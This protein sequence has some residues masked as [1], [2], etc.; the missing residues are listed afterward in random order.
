MSNAC[1]PAVVKSAIRDAIR[2]GRSVS[3]MPSRLDTLV[4]RVADPQLRDEL[5]TAVDDLRRI[6]DFGL[7]FEKHLPETVRLPHHSI[8]RG[9]KV[10]RR[11]LT[12]HSLFEVIAVNKSTATIRRLRHA[13][14][15]AVSRDEAR[16]TPKETAPIADLVALAE[17]GDPIYP[18]LRRIDGIQRGADKPSHVVINGE[19]YHTVQLLQFT[20]AA[21]VDFIYIDP[22]Y[23][24]TD[25]DWKYNNDYVDRDDA[26]RHSK[27]LAF[28]HRR[29]EQAKTLLNPDNSVL[30][31]R[32]TRTSCTGWR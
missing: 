20:H 5:R 27:W 26:Y 1:P 30:T 12:D 10:T 7:V 25:K 6:T 14:G 29:L 32:S 22:P 31:S 19:N 8:R 11:D 16:D 24:T 4:G 28:M 18:G 15:S 9:I 21:K 3:P 2:H 23:N 17:F 13:D